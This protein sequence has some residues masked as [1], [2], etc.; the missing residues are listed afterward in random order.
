MTRTVRVTRKDFRED[1]QGRTFSD[2]LDDAE[3]P[4]DD[5]LAFLQQFRTPASH[6]RS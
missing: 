6:G 1:R 5:V 4:F 2:V 3:L